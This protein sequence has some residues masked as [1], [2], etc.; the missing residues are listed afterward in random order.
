MGIIV[1]EPPSATQ[2]RPG[3]AREGQPDAFDGSRT[4]AFACHGC[5]NCCKGSTVLLSPF[6]LARLAAAT[7]ESPRTLV[8]ERCAVLKHPMTDLPA[9][10]LETV[11]RCSLLDDA[12]RCTVYAHRP[13]VCRAYPLGVRVD[14]NASG[15]QAPLARFTVRANPCPPPAPGGA[16]LP[17]VSTLH[18]L[19]TASGLEP[20]AEA[21][22]AWARLCWDI[23]FTWR[24]REMPTIEVLAFDE[25]FTRVFYREVEAPADE[26]EALLAFLR[27]ASAFRAR[28]RVPAANAAAL[29][30]PPG[31]PTTART[32]PPP[33]ASPAP[34]P[35]S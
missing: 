4:I 30:S 20:F 6:D 14:L 34:P 8:K 28:H 21:Y 12:D 35:R 27:R 24:Y 10:M 22:R 16:P 26:G 1:D 32:S 5:G 13:L 23:A 9:L 33:L 2:L 31:A 11:P 7:G 25:E 19:A 18:A 29:N 17:V 3:Q 15:W